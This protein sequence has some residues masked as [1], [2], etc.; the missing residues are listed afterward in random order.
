MK[1][2]VATP[3]VPVVCGLLKA[4]GAEK[5]GTEVSETES[6]ATGRPFASWTVTATM[7]DAVPPGPESSAGF[8]LS[9]IV[10]LADDGVPDAAAG[11][12]PTTANALIA[13][14]TAAAAAPKRL[15]DWTSQRACT[16]SLERNAGRASP[17]PSLRRGYVFPRLY[18]SDSPC[19]VGGRDPK[20]WLEYAGK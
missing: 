16:A 8:G 5:F 12:G 17:R 11:A 20:R 2:K 10:E 19:R 18:S 3:F 9:E 15:Q 14:T 7:N 1:A 4:D 6:P 13:S